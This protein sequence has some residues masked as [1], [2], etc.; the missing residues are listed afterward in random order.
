MRRHEDPS[1]NRNSNPY[2][3]PYSYPTKEQ[4]AL[5]DLLSRVNCNDRREPDPDARAAE[6][7]AARTLRQVA[8]TY[9]SAFL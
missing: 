8:V 1:T 4:A 9:L 2:P 3:A 6:E 5:Q 7:Y